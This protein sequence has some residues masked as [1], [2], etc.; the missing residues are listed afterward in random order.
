MDV[1]IALSVVSLPQTNAAPLVLQGR[2][3]IGKAYSVG[4][5]RSTVCHR[6]DKSLGFGHGS[7]R[8]LAVAEALVD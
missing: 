2:R 3:L 1:K 6:V 4:N 7:Y 5:R 8:K